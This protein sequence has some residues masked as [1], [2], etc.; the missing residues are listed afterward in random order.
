MNDYKV[1]TMQGNPEEL[2]REFILDD[3]PC[4]MAL[5][6]VADDNLTIKNYQKIS[7]ANTPSKIL[8][9]LESYLDSIEEEDK[10]FQTFIATFENDTFKNEINFEN[11]LWKLLSNLNALDPKPWD[12][13]TS[14]DPSSTKFSFSLLNNSFYVVGMHPESSRKARSAPFPMI[15]FNLHSQFEL[16]REAGRYTRVRDIIRRRD[17]AFQGS[18]N[19]MLDDF[20]NSSE[21]RQY[22]G[23]E[24]EADWKC[25]YNFKKI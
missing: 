13:N 16:L 5:S 25:P 1:D 11:A 9:D 2:I 6:L 4:V 18:I 23:R 10:K 7:N 24:V 8:Q 15:V 21:A 22:S 3:H 19:P 17:K 14:A 20:G 12:K